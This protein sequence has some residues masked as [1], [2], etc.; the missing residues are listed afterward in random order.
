MAQR[1]N[2]AQ[3]ESLYTLM[4]ESMSMDEQAI[5]AYEA[6]VVAMASETGVSRGVIEAQLDERAWG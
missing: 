1:I 4:Q 3:V 5:E 2:E 6:A